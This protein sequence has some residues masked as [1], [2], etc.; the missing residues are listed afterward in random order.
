MGESAPPEEAKPPTPPSTRA[1]RAK[2]RAAKARAAKA[3]QRRA[4]P[5]TSVEPG[6]IH[7]K[8]AEMT[9]QLIQAKAAANAGLSL[10]VGELNTKANPAGITSGEDGPE[11]AE[12]LARVFAH[13]FHRIPG[14]RHVEK[15]LEGTDKRSGP[16]SDVAA[17][18]AQLYARNEEVIEGAAKQVVLER[19]LKKEGHNVQRVGGF[20]VPGPPV[21]P[22]EFNVETFGPNLD[23]PNGGTPAAQVEGE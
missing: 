9:L 8:L 1:T 23:Q 11:P 16:L 3:R 2:A 21:A 13:L 19:A 5:P 14:V 7:G 4:K 10:Q 18:L 12:I 17:L 22:P 20:P 6:W 15:K